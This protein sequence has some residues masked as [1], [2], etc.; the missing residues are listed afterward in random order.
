VEYSEGVRRKDWWER[1]G[2]RWCRWGPS[3]L[4]QPWAAVGGGGGGRRGRA[5]ASKIPIF[6]VGSFRS[7]SVFMAEDSILDSFYNEL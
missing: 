5:Q 1:R 2:R 3:K 4:Q 7:N 6:T